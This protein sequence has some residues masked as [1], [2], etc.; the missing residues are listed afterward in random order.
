MH[1]F[2]VHVSWGSFFWYDGAYSD[3]KDTEWYDIMVCWGGAGER[4]YACQGEPLSKYMP[5]VILRYTVDLF[6]LFL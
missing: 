4:A 2:P 6:L 5:E 3:T 1:R